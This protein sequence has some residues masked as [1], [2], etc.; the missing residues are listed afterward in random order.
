MIS[1]ETI[2]ILLFAFFIAE[3]RPRTHLHKTRT[4]WKRVIRGS[5][6]RYRQQNAAGKIQHKLHFLAPL[7]RGSKLTFLI[8]AMRR[9]GLSLQHAPNMPGQIYSS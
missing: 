8:D 3:S 2:K 9:D 5:V 1:N 4:Y 7:R 6:Q